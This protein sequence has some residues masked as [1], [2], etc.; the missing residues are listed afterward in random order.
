MSVF[1]GFVGPAHE[2]A[3]PLQ[4]AQR[5]INW[6]VESDGNAEAKEHKALLACPGLLALATASGEVRGGWVLPGET[7]ALWVCGSTVYLMTITTPATATTLPGVS[8]TSVGTLSTSTGQVC[9]RDN[10]AGGIAVIVDGPNGYVYKIA[11]HTVTKITDP[12]FLGADRVA[13]IDGWLIF[14]RPNTQQFYTSPLYWNGITAMDGTYF[15]SKD[16]NT[17]NLVTFIE[18]L[19]ELW[20]IGERSTEIWYDAGGP[21]FPFGRLNGPMLQVGCAAKHT[22]VR[23]GTGL[24]WLA[25]NERGQNVVVR[26]E[27][28]AY[29]TVSNHAI[30]TAIASYPVV[31]DAIAYLYQE[32]GHP[33]YV[34]TF[35][36]ADVTWVYDMAENEWHQRARFTS[37]VF[38]RHRSN[39]YLNFANMR[40]VGDYANGKI[41]RMSRDYYDDAG[42]PLV[43]VRRAPHVWDEKNRDRVYHSQLQV[44]FTPGV[45][46]QTGQG[47]DPQAMLRWSDDGGQTWSNIRSTSIGAAGRTKNRAMWRRLGQARDRVYEV[48]MSD[49]VKRDIVGASLEATE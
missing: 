49:P 19:R 25:K 32:A 9:I 5:L 33:F 2:A 20:L 29:T 22:I 23:A 47:S 17:D 48:S 18:A 12:A 44:E 43:T 31:S 39:C 1:K 14:N 42:D 10:G 41:Y 26:T 36:T 45:G 38:G 16:S 34:L 13:F 11:L 8:I 15:A 40:L 35:P 3:N 24:M 21:L 37:G 4:D 46:K 27:G 28:Y 6:Y 7:Q 30:E